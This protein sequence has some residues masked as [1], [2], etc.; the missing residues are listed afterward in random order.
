MSQRAASSAVQNTEASSLLQ[1]SHWI[2]IEYYLSL[3]SDQAS[4]NLLLQGEE[5]EGKEKKIS[6]ETVGWAKIWKGRERDDKYNMST[7]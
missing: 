7:T 1:T 6:G 2:F 3:C 5:R 4:Y